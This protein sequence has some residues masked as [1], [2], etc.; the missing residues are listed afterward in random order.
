MAAALA[1]VLMGA[2][3]WRGLFMIGA[4]PLVTLFSLAYFKMPESVVWL[5][6]RGRIAEARAL[7]A[8]TGIDT[9]ETAPQLAKSIAEQSMTRQAGA[10]R[11]GRV[12]SS[13]IR[14][15]RSCFG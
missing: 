11:A 14:S 10:S 12:C 6:A 13:L 3:G 8:R 2:I 9:P 4:L 1:I 15:Q 7:A 5:A